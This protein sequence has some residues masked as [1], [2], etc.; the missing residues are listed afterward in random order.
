MPKLHITA[1]F[2]V[3]DGARDQARIM[4]ALDIPAQAFEAAIREAAKCDVSIDM[5]VVKHKALAAEAV[6][7]PAIAP[8][9]PEPSVEIPVI[10]PVSAVL[11]TRPRHAA[12]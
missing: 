1:S 9:P 2:D 10:D 11:H 5:R 8:P 3:P 4:A 12:E 6:A 7:V